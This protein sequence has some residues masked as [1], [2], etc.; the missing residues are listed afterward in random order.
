MTYV[1]TLSNGHT[2]AFLGTYDLYE[3][4]ATGLLR[5]TGKSYPSQLWSLY[6]D[7]STRTIASANGLETWSQQNAPTFDGSNNPIW[8]TTNTLATIPVATTEP[9]DVEDGG[10]ASLVPLRAGMKTTGGVLVSYDALN[11]APGTHT[12][13]HR[14]WHLG[15]VL[16]G[17]SHWLWTTSHTVPNNYNSVYPSDGSFAAMNGNTSLFLGGALMTVDRH[18][19][20]QYVGAGGANKFNHFYDDGLFVDT[21]GADGIMNAPPMAAVDSYSCWLVKL[22]DG[23][24]YMYQNDGGEHSGVRRWRIDGLGTVSEQNSNVTWTRSTVTQAGPSLAEEIIPT[25][26]LDCVPG[27][28][29]SNPADLLSGLLSDA[30]VTAGVSGDYGWSW[31]M[32]PS[33][34]PPAL[35]YAHTNKKSLQRPSGRSMPGS[36]SRTTP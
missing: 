5:N 24:V 20:T 11:F 36:I 29:V 23:R 15:G 14:G 8:G 33:E 31:S 32:P 18:I 6:A 1:T 4:P 7:G 2:Y 28:G 21:W 30:N 19:L 35:W 16:P 12:P 27:V 25:T 26:R 9:H 10:G 13:D 17:G 3:L 34:S 22:A